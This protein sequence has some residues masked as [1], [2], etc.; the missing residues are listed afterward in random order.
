MPFSKSQDLIRLAR[1]AAVRRTGISL[2]EIRDEFGI[3]HRTAQRMTEAL[4]A[5]FG[6]VEAVTGPDRRRRWRVLDPVLEKLQLRQETA[7]EA[8]EIASKTARG[9]GRLR[10]A[11]ALDDLRGGLLAR[12]TPKD[13]LRTEADVEA[14]LLGMGSVTRPGPRV[15]LVPAVVDAVIEA[16][17]GPFRLRIRYGTLEAPERVVEPHGFLL[18]HRS[19]LVARQPERGD[20]MRNFRMDR[21]MS[22][23]SLDESFNIAPGFSLEDYTARSFGVYQNPK[24]YDEVIWRFAPHAAARAAEF[25]FNPKQTVEPQE[26]GSLVVRFHAAGWLEMAWHLYSWGDAVEVVAPEGLRSLIENHRRTDFDSLP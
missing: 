8:L 25:S 4:E 17:R 5:V 16:L 24:Q 1:L 21:I 10:H 22:A 11:A 7:I 23:Q 20:E 18:G 14:V 3:S 26:D 15:N 2:D 9:E 6:T 12:L 13:A 19:Y